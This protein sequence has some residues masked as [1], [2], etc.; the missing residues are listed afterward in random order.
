MIDMLLKINFQKISKYIYMSSGNDM[1]DEIPHSSLPPSNPKDVH[2]GKVEEFRQ[3]LIKEGIIKKGSNLDNDNLHL[4]LH[5]NSF[6]ISQ[7]HGL[8]DD[9]KKYNEWNQDCMD[10]YITARP[11]R[12][13]HRKPNLYRSFKEM[14][15][16]PNDDELLNQEK[17]WNGPFS[18]VTDIN[19][20][21]RERDMVAGKKEEVDIFKAVIDMI[22]TKDTIPMNN[23][24]MNSIIN[25]FNFKIVS[26][27][28]DRDNFIFRW[29]FKN[30]NKK[31]RLGYFNFH[32]LY[33]SDNMSSPDVKGKMH[34][35][36]LNATY[37][38]MP[39]DR[40]INWQNSDTSYIRI[41]GE[42][43]NPLQ[44]FKLIKV[45]P[46][47]LTDGENLYTLKHIANYLITVFDHFSAITS[48]LD[49]EWK[50]MCHIYDQL[51]GSNSKLGSF[52]T[53]SNIKPDSYFMSFVKDSHVVYITL[54]GEFHQIF[55]ELISITGFK[56]EDA[57][58]YLI[59][60]LGDDVM[61]Y[62]ESQHHDVENVEKKFKNYMIYVLLFHF[63]IGP[64]ELING[65]IENKYLKYKK[66]Y[67]ELK[68]KLNL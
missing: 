42:R 25:N 41:K 17:D 6:V 58:K 66:K 7:K 22:E 19:S 36:I 53:L 60:G 68:K 63:Y 55:D 27:N 67:L 49:P 62:F 50:H 59:Y 15:A 65:R 52:F 20:A 38:S 57:M 26:D 54:K 4:N 34:M 61:Q 14:P 30:H 29:A 10:N 56:S 47:A 5:L 43:T 31:F 40:D 39:N 1:N 18:R 28:S 13:Y 3:A 64:L 51:S 37:D 9:I 21:A 16:Q 24:P 44:V 45:I 12:P 48:I 46:P 35:S 11:I 23:I 2:T 33:H 32:K 8:V